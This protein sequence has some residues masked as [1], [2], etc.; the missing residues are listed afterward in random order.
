MTG[1]GWGGGRG[2]SQNPEKQP[3]H[4]R[5]GTGKKLPT[6]LTHEVDS[7]FIGDMRDDRQKLLEMSSTEKERLSE[8]GWAREA[9]ETSGDSEIQRWMMENGAQVERGRRPRMPA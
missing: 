6:R 9:G 7:V 2:S 8:H 4:M 5:V 1:V 3:T